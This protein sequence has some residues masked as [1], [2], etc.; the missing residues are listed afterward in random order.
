ML[1]ISEAAEEGEFAT[2]IILKENT[3]IIFKILEE[4]GT[5]V[6]QMAN[7]RDTLLPGKWRMI[8]IKKPAEEIRK[9]NKQVDEELLTS[10]MNKILRAVAV[11]KDSIDIN[12][13][14]YGLPFSGIFNKRR[15]F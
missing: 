3:K 15:R 4:E 11:N 1:N 14:S 9:A 7:I 8:E 6:V 5:L 2:T 13:T 12:V 10:I